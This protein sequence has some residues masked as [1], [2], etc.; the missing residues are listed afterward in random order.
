MIRRRNLCSAVAGSGFLV[1]S[2]LLTG[3]PVAW[4]DELAGL[5]ANQERLQQRIDQLSQAA[6]GSIPIPGQYVPGFGPPTGAPGP[7]QPVV[8]GSFPRSFLVPGTAT[9]IRIGGFANAV[10]QWYASGANQGGQLNGQGG[11]NNNT[12]FDGPGG[13]GNLPNIP[14]NNTPSHSRSNAFDLSPRTSR[15]LFDAR[16]PTAWGEIKAYVEFDFAYNNT[17]VIQSN[18]QGTAMSE[19]A[20]LRKAYGT[21]AGFEGGLDVGIMHDGDADPELIDGGASTNGRLRTT[22]LKYTYAGPYGTVFNFGGEQPDATISTPFGK[23]DIDSNAIPGISA[24]SPTGIAGNVPSNTPSTNACLS[25]F[26]TFNTLQAVAPEV[27]ATART[28]QP[29]GHITIGGVLR[30]QVM[31]DGQYLYRNYLGGAG[32]IGG[33][34]HPFS[35]APGPFGKD[36]LGFQMAAG[37]NSGNQVANGAGVATNF[38]GIINVPGVGF[39]NPLAATTGTACSG[40]MV[41]TA[42]GC[43]AGTTSATAAWNARASTQSLSGFPNSGGFINGVN[44]R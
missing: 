24:C 16:T 1:V 13:T 39:V 25:S 27:V 28:N 38:G 22:Q 36:D 31:N 21:F 29:W 19:F 20:R 41:A 11:I 26:S 14:L 10:A 12:F 17:N 5:R 3:S 35:G 4:A 44:V 43:P 37:P 42:S 8:S 34:V 2:G 33:D 23:N 30:N 9:S 15:L 18:N 32:T 6:P 7:N 40:G